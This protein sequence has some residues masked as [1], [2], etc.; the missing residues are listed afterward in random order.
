MSDLYGQPVSEGTI[1]DSWLDTVT[2]AAPVNAQ[3]KQQL[4]THETVTHHDETGARVNEKLAWL[5]STSTANLTY[6]ELYEKRGSQALDAIGIL[7]EC[8]GTVVHD[9]YSLRSYEF[10]SFCRLAAVVARESGAAIQATAR[11]VGGTD[12]NAVRH[13]Y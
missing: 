5:H 13:K 3:V 4:T 12:T 6:D 8:T 2:E 10:A 7:P 9:D 1:V 11:T